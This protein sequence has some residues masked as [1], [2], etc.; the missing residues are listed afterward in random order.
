MTTLRE[1][2]ALRGSIAHWERM[3]E[4]VERQ[5]HYNKPDIGDMWS[6]IHED[7]RGASCDLCL[8]YNPNCGICT[9]CPLGP[10]GCC[11]EW[12]AVDRS[13]TWLDWLVAAN[14]MLA[15]LESELKKAEGGE[16]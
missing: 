12:K 9:R 4:W 3:I 10:R 1:L 6:E 7:W 5:P 8:L 2:E 13:D 14:V 11:D 16:G 15:R